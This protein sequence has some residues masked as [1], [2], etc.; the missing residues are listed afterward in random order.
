MIKTQ[1]MIDTDDIYHLSGIDGIRSFLVDKNNSNVS[2]TIIQENYVCEYQGP[3]KLKIDNNRLY[4]ECSVIHWAYRILTPIDGITHDWGLLSDNLNKSLY[5]SV[6][7]SNLALGINCVYSAPYGDTIANF[8][9]GTI[10]AF[11]NITQNYVN[12]YL[13]ITNRYL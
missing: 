9:I 2:S 6:D 4:S 5:A 12:G 8:L 10:D 13:Q 3:W 7:C 1:K 11:G